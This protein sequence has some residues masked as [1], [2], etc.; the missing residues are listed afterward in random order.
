MPRL[1]RFLDG[2]LRLYQSEHGYRFSLDAPLLADFILCRAGDTLLEIGSGNG[3]IPL[4]LHRKKHF[5]RIHAV[6]LQPALA[7][8]AAANFVLNGAEDRIRVVQGDIRTLSATELPMGVD[9]VFANPPYRRVGQ[10][11]LNPDRERAVARHELFLS[12]AELMTAARHWLRPGGSFF[13]IH[14]YERAEEVTHAADTAGF[15]LRR[16]RL[17]YS[18]PGSPTPGMILLHWTTGAA[19]PQFLPDLYIYEKDRVYGAEFRRIISAE[20]DSD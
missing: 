8:L 15:H 11:L 5:H 7:E 2:R 10:G 9:G 19:A 6:E 18:R 4:I 17:V 20:A 12:L 14:L 16:Q 3:I 13:L 1:T